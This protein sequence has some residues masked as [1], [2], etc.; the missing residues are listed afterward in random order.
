MK[1]P[2]PETRTQASLTITYR[3]SF[4]GE[5][6]P[7]MPRNKRCI[8]IGLERPITRGADCAYARDNLSRPFCDFGGE[9]PYSRRQRPLA[10]VENA[11]HRM[12]RTLYTL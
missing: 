9:S 3:T 12:E 10:D 11:W 1:I 5:R 6:V 2:P 4:R 8:W 7:L